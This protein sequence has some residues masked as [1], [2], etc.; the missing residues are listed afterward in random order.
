MFCLTR[1]DL[2]VHD[3]TAA[4]D[5]YEECIGLMPA[6]AGVGPESGALPGCVEMD[7][8]AVRVR[9]V[10]APADTPRARLSLEVN[11]V[12]A[13]VDVLREAGA[14][15][16]RAPVRRGTRRPLSC[17]ARDPFGNTLFVW[18][19]PTE[20]DLEAPPELDTTRGWDP[21]AVALMKSMLLH[22]P[23]LFRQ[24]A[25]ISSVHWAETLPGDRDVSVEV[26]VRGYVRATPAF[27]RDRLLRALEEHGFDPD[28]YAE[29]FNTAEGVGRSE[30]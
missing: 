14:E 12:D 11:D 16:L 4:R 29:Y 3:V 8:G 1:I 10:P 9:L 18:R 20:D 17:E 23:E 28:G 27:G 2:P 15:I 7:S 26:A 24:P 6:A 30:A 13:A 19:A 21:A 22:V 5:F 25:R